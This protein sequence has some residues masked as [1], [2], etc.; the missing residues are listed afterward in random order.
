MGGRKSGS[1]GHFEEGDPRSYGNHDE[2]QRN[3]RWDRQPNSYTN[4]SFRREE[5]ACSHSNSLNKLQAA[6]QGI[7]VPD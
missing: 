6:L 1:R 7:T 3:Q 5:A 2:Q 4:D